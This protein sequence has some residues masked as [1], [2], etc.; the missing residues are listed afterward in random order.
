MDARHMPGDGKSS[1]GL[2]P[3]ELKTYSKIKQ[4]DKINLFFNT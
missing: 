1:H 3:D 4:K 2:R